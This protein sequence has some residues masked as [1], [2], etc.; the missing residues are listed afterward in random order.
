MEEAL[1]VW[2]RQ[3]QGRDMTLTED[4]IHSKAKQLGTQLGVPETYAYSSGWLY[5]FKRRYGIKSYVMRGEAGSAN[6]EGIDLAHSNVRELLT[7]GAYEA[8]YLQSG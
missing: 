4:I 1:Y 7:E 2:F 3:M 8:G 6:Q 5:N